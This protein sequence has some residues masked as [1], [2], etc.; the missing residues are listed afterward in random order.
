M[1]A[2][3]KTTTHNVVVN[4]LKID[5]DS[6][7]MRQIK[8]IFSKLGILNAYAAGEK[9]YVGYDSYM[10]FVFGEFSNLNLV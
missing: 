1:L 7:V 6:L 9:Q 10:S 2:R 5:P 4:D 3:Q 8:S